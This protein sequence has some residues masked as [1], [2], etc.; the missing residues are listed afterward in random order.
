MDFPSLS[1]EQVHFQLLS[2]NFIQILLNSVSNKRRPWSDHM[3]GSRK[4]CQRG[5]TVTTFFGFFFSL[6][7]RRRIQIPLLAGH[8][9]PASEMPFYM[10]F[11]WRTDGGP[12]L[13]AGFV[14]L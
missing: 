3:L 4:F 8:Q 7:R 6:M 13:N 2:A 10:A 1:S 12:T 11:R 5:P 9:Q 14:A